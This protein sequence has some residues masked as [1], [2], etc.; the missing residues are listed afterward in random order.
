VEEKDDV[1]RFGSPVF[2]VDAGDP[3]LFL[4]HGDQDPQ[5][6]CAGRARRGCW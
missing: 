2:H 3:P 1:A 6:S 4:L 5:S